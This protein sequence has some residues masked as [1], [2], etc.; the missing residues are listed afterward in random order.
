M[1]GGFDVLGDVDTVKFIEF[2]LD[3]VGNSYEGILTCSSVS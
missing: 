2:F 1:A 3:R